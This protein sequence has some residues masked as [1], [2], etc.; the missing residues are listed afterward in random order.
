MTTATEELIQFK[1]NNGLRKT[2]ST[3]N[4]YTT[5]G[6]QTTIDRAVYPS[7]GAYVAQ[8][9]RT[10]KLPK[11]A[12]NDHRLSGAAELQRLLA[13]QDTIVKQ[14]VFVKIASLKSTPMV[15]VVRELIMQEVLNNR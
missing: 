14:R 15:N 8:K 13:G 11:G 2:S 6:R 3:G 12:K 9:S 10:P 5:P 1:A 7:D 4:F